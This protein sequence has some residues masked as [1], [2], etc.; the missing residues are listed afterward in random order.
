MRKYDVLVNNDGR[1]ELVRHGFNWVAFWLTITWALFKFNF[2]IIII[3]IGIALV[4]STF[5]EYVKIEENMV[6]DVISLL[7]G[8]SFHVFFG[9]NGNQWTKKRLLNKNYNLI[10][11]VSAHFLSEAYEDAKELL[12]ERST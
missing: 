9:L 4:L 3:I 12:N 6:T 7:L 11:S 2:R 1:I 5:F 8:I 10:G